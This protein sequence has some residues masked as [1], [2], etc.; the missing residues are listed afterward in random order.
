VEEEFARN[1]SLADLGK[2]VLSAREP[3]INEE[4]LWPKFVIKFNFQKHVT[5]K[6]MC[7]EVTKWSYMYIFY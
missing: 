4:S 3:G 1:I 6:K 7:R 2:S 5:L